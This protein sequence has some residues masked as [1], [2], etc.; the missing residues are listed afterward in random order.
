MRRS[1]YVCPGVFIL[2]LQSMLSGAQGQR[3]DS[4]SFGFLLQISPQ[5]YPESLPN[6]SLHA[7]HVYLHLR[8]GW[9]RLHSQ[10]ALRY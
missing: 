4:V 3:C 8:K 1:Q 6:P 5:F 7:V 10:L 9:H 2:V